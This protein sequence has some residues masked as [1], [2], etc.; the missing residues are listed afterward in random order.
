MKRIKSSWGT[1]YRD[2]RIAPE[3]A[4]NSIRSGNTVY[5]G[6]CCGEP[7]TLVQALVENAKG[8]RDIKIVNVSPPY[9]PSPYAQIEMAEHFRLLTFFGN[10]ETREAIK[11]DRADYIPCHLSDIPA[12]F[13]E[14]HLQLDVALVQVSPPDTN[15]NCSLG[16]S[17]DCTKAAIEN[18]K[19]VIA[20]INT[21]MPRTLGDS[22]IHISRFHRWVDSSNPLITIEF[23]ENFTEEER[24]VGKNVAS[25]IPEG[26]TLALGFGKIVNAI[27]YSLNDKRDIGIHTGTISDGIIPLVEKGVITNKKKTID[28]GRIVASM[29]MGSENLYRFCHNNSIIEMRRVEYTHNIAT[30]IQLNNLFSI[31]SAFQVDLYGQVSAEAMNGYHIGGT[32]GQVDFVRGSKQ[33]RGGGSMICLLSTAKGDTISRIVPSLKPFIPVTSLRADIDHVVT[34]FGVASLKGKSLRE[35]ARALIKV[36]HPN[37]RSWLSESFSEFWPTRGMIP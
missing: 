1:A 16:I 26:A 6:S 21:K 36:A 3:E 34:E 27:L 32:G 12:L 13:S 4:V 29:A 33:S 8:L 23:D 25:L 18:A 19:L 28:R 15:G 17:V 35:R 31:N 37:F 11:E 22:F 20:E 30:L 5:L 24:A 10:P 14:G 7:Q 9:G 2:K